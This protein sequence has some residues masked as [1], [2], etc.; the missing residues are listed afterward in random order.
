MMKDLE[1]KS[2]Q[3][4]L[5]NYKKG[6]FDTRKALEKITK[7]KPVKQSRNLFMYYASGLVASVLI[8][9]GGYVFFR[10]SEE[11]ATNIVSSNEV[12][13]CIL[14]DSTVVILAPG[15]TLSYLPE[16]FEEKNRNVKMKGKAFFSVTRDKK[17]PFL[18]Y[19]QHSATKVLGT[20]FQINEQ[21]PDSITEIYVVSGQVY[22]SSLLKEGEGLVLIKGMEAALAFN[23]SKPRIT[24]PST[25]NPSAWAENVFVYNDAPVMDVLKELSD[26]F[27]VKLATS[28]TDKKITAEFRA[29][30]L[31]NIL[32]IMEKT[33]EV[34]IKKE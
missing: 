7:E 6:M 22:F 29:D 27:G 20:K 14:P 15:S 34:K 23:E 9:V 31:D 25:L 5:D 3:F 13:R 2:L 17:S 1:D 16:D 26:F 11:L 10:T 30:D 18:V 19:G 8:L 24:E 21:R 12:V 4:V 28:E 32:E 33:L